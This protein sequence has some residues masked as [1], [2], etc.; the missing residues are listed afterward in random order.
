MRIGKEVGEDVWPLPLNK[1]HYNAIKSDIADIKSTGGNP[2][3]SIG[4]AVIGTFIDADRPWVH[5]DI[6]G[7][8]WLDKAIPTTPKG[9]AGWGVRFMD[10]V[11]RDQEAK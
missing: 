8:D 10:G 1:N 11:I 6:A 4:A 2:G 9:H 7:V 5:L 3:A